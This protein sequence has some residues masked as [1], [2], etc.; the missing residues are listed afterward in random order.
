MYIEQEIIAIITEHTTSEVTKNA[1]II[2]DLMADSLDLCEIIFDIE[3]TFDIEELVEHEEFKNGCG[4]ITVAELI[5]KVEKALGH[6]VN[7]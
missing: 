4:D 3:E 2:S 5:V 7:E 6:V 1:H